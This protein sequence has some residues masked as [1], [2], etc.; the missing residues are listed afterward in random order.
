MND[1]KKMLQIKYAD[2]QYGMQ[3]IRHNSERSLIFSHSFCQ[4]VMT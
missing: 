2:Y 3:L 4:E 1:T